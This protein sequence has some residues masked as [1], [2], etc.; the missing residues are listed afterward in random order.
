MITSYYNFLNESSSMG[1]TEKE[2]FLLNK[3]NIF[4]YEF[5][6]ETELIDCNQ[7]IDLRNRRF[8]YLPNLRLGTVKGDFHCDNNKLVSLKNEPKIVRG[9]FVCE[10]NNLSNL[11]YCP[12]TVTGDFFC[13]YNPSE[14]IEDYPR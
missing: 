5:N 11:D 13:G 8:E 10:R 9:N 7:S 2:R 14:G 1:I 4:Y 6:Q 12:K 3:Y